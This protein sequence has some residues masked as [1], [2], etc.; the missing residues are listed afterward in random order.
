MINSRTYRAPTITEAVDKVKREL[1]RDAIILQTR[2][3]RKGGLLGFLGGQPMWEVQA[4]SNL[5][6]PQ[7][8]ISGEYVS[9][10]SSMAPLGS[11]QDTPMNKVHWVGT[12]PLV[13]GYQTAACNATGVLAKLREHL[14]AQDVEAPL[15]SNI[16]DELLANL[17]NKELSDETHLRTR[18]ADL[19]A[20]RMGVIDPAESTTR[21]AR[22]R[23]ITLIG[24]TGVGKTTT[25]AKMAANYK[26]R[27]NKKVGLITID[28]YRIAAV[29]QLR[30]YAE[31]MDIPVQAVFSPGELHN[32][33]QRMSEMDVILVDTVG[34]SQNDRVRLNDLAKFITVSGSDEVHLTIS[35]ATNPRVARNTAD[36]FKPLGVNR[37]I[38]T[39]LDEAETF[40]M[41]LNVVAAT[42]AAISYV[43]TGQDVPDDITRADPN[44]LAR[45][46]MKGSWHAN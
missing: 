6:I 9:E 39:K 32:A 26:L 25:I 44:I 30:T 10:Q 19:I 11:H 12:E 3:F 37:I 16:M 13:S 2:R 46:I 40:G 31:I 36:H 34:R 33:V 5:N 42:D 8:P 20:K 35:I 21:A 28:T 18:L 43:T 24:P 7:I 45:C 15:V 14:L 1:G 17:P 22:T 41:M 27:S 38:I 29:D 4:A 23:V